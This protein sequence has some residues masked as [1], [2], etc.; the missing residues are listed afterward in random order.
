MRL[1]HKQLI[2]VLPREQLV[3]QWRELSAIAGN[4]LTKGTPNHILVNKVMDYPLAHFVTYASM[5]RKEMTRRGYKTMDK[6]WDKIASVTNDKTIV[7][8]E[9]IY[10]S[11]MDYTYYVICY[12]NL[13]EK[14]LCGGISQADWDRIDQNGKS[15]IIYKTSTTN[16]NICYNNLT[17]K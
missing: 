2:S 4:I 16:L 5:V 15:P 12:Y 7:S 14:Y 10:S 8:T 6:V 3:A 17:N 13:Y 11:W 1:W 9:D